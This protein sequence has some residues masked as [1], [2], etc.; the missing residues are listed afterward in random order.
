MKRAVL[1][2]AL[3]TACGGGG[4]DTPPPDVAIPPTLAITSPASIA[5]TDP[6]SIDLAI[7]G[8]PAGAALELVVRPP[9]VAPIGDELRMVQVGVEP[10]L[11]APQWLAAD[12]TWS[13]TEVAY[14]TTPAA[15][16]QTIAL[17]LPA[18]RAGEWRVIATLVTAD[19][20]AS[21]FASAS[22]IATAQPALR[23]SVD[24]AWANLLDP[25]AATAQVVT[26]GHADLQLV[27]W[28]TTPDGTT[29]SLPELA[30]SYRVV[31]RVVED[32]TVTLLHTDLLAFGPGDYRVAARLVDADGNL[33]AAGGG[34][35]TVC[36]TDGTIDGHIVDGQAAAIAVD[37]DAVITISSLDHP[38]QSIV[39]AVDPTGAFHADLAV[40]TWSVG[41]P[42]IDASGGWRL[43][44]LVFEVGCAGPTAITVTAAS[45]T[46]FPARVAVPPSTTP[47][48]GASVAERGNPQS[49]IKIRALYVY[50][51]GVSR[52]PMFPTLVVSRLRDAFG[53]TVSFQTD[54]AVDALAKVGTLT[55]LTG[56]DDPR[57]VEGLGNLLGQF[58]DLVEVRL[59]RVGRRWILY[60]T[61]VTP[62]ADL[63]VRGQISTR[64]DEPLDKLVPLVPGLATD[65]A[66]R[67]R[68]RLHSETD[69][70]L[71]TPMLSTSIAPTTPVQAGSIA[72]TVHLKDLDTCIPAPAGTPIDL[73]YDLDA[74]ARGTAHLV[75]DTTGSATW[76]GS[77]PAVG[78]RG[79][80]T[81]SYTD[82]KGHVTIGLPELVYYRRVGNV[83]LVLDKV[84]AVPRSIVKATLRAV[85]RGQVLPFAPMAPPALTPAAGK[86][87]TLIASAGT[88]PAQVTTDAN[89]K[90]TY[91]WTVGDEGLGTTAAIS[92]EIGQDDT[93][94]LVEP[95]HQVAVSA[96]P[97]DIVL[98]DTPIDINAL[99]TL[100][101]GVPAVGLPVRLVDSGATV[102]TVVTDDGGRA[103]L[104]YRT[105]LF[106]GS[107]PLS[108]SATYDGVTVTKPLTIT[109]RPPC[110]PSCPPVVVTTDDPDHAVAKGGTIRFFANQ[111]V[112]WS[113]TGGSIGTDGTLTAAAQGGV[114]TVTAVSTENPGATGTLDYVIDCD[115]VEM[116]GVYAGMQTI[117]VTDPS[118]SCADGAG[119][120]GQIQ[121]LDHPFPDTTNYV[122][123]LYDIIPGSPP[124]C[125]QMYGVGE[126]NFPPRIE[127]CTI[128]QYVE[129]QPFGCLIQS[130]SISAKGPGVAGITGHA[131]YGQQVGASCVFVDDE[132]FDM[133]RVP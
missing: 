37:G 127:H 87:F 97:S 30:P 20:K 40:G 102:A 10:G 115:D 50:G 130:I 95:P 26:A 41:E 104:P 132:D 31:P 5:P 107:F 11:G 51:D 71:R 47:A 94:L 44:P 33:V 45:K 85:M 88:L 76:T 65:L 24:H 48:P 77:V 91:D 39:A 35:F 86:T 118:F 67:G 52:D 46:G 53:R 81:P 21:A 34:G 60:V 75:V 23:V 90:A 133:G 43:A 68:E 6:W 126:L 119:A 80:F 49:P 12:G 58:D 29:V 131:A 109:A 79:I 96:F 83:E 74:G 120:T 13:P 123:V 15:G 122:D 2:L 17:A 42:V 18:A 55:Q 32:Q 72:V 100:T 106:P 101:S 117:D 9:D 108:V 114:W 73:Q 124:T 27:G 61:I 84:K 112:V 62:Q 38:S 16:T 57:L 89:G 129:S 69:T 93:G 36:D 1:V 4:D 113:A 103:T 128:T 116:I 63:V 54:E 25:V 111:E 64:D 28:L 66:Y 19:A 3:V 82:A 99:V 8:D 56:R 7:T 98:T 14:Q 59:G 70:A 22:T 105:S 92:A 110:A 121:I 78:R 125:E